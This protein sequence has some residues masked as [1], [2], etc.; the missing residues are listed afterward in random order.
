MEINQNFVSLRKYSKDPKAIYDL[1]DA[2]IKQQTSVY[3]LAADSKLKELKASNLQ[4]LI[5][6]HPN[7]VELVVGH[8]G[9]PGLIPNTKKISLGVYGILDTLSSFDCWMEGS[10]IERILKLPQVTSASIDIEKSTMLKIMLGMAR[11]AYGYDP[12]LKKNAATGS[13]KGSI[14]YDLEKYGLSIDEETIRKYLKEAAQ[15][16]MSGLQGLPKKSRNTNYEVN[17]A[18]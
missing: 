4:S 18:K 8:T 17:E 16:H 1:L 15:T 6:E 9:L 5:S 10:E 13:N 14:K 2:G 7:K 11:A 12:S 3:R